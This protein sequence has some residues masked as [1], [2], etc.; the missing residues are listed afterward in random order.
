MSSG[1]H[2][3]LVTGGAGFVGTHVVK[4]LV[5]DGHTVTAM[6]REKKPSWLPA[7]VSWITADL[8]DAATL[9]P[10]NQSFSGIIHLA[11]QSV[12]AS[13]GAPQDIAWNA[14]MTQGLIEAVPPTRLLLVSSAHVYR[15]AETPLSETSDT[16]PKGR[17][18]ISKLLAEEV[19]TIAGRTFDVR[20]ARPFNHIGSGMPS[21]LMVPSLIARLLSLP[22]GEPLIMKG[23]NSIRD[24]LDVS[25]IVDAYLCLLFLENPKERIFNVC[26]E[27]GRSVA[28][29]AS[30]SMKHLEQK[31][32]I[33][34]E[35]SLLSTDDTPLLVGSSQRIR[36]FTNWQP[37]TSIE[38][39]L[40]TLVSSQLGL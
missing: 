38:E 19:A 37:A 30:I 12:P 5:R 40:K 35:S 18:G 31:R 27:I 7:T 4:R 13:F 22:K 15:S 28:D 34:F 2:H 11:A 39:S 6:G 16:Y 3:I 24:Y 8:L 1:K 14:A 21:A 29:I 10:L 9:A 25:D 23:Q 26:S 17:Y 36:N 32:E 20:I 33:I